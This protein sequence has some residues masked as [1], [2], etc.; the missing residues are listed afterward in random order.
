M[1]IP[2]LNEQGVLPPGVHECTL[3]EVGARFGRFA[4]TSQRPDLFA[5]LT[6]Y[7]GELSKAGVANA[8]II[9]GSF[10]TAVPHP[11]DIDLIV[12]LKEGVSQLATQ[13]PHVYNVISK[14]RVS[15][16]NR[17]DIVPVRDNT[18]DLD[19]AIAF[20]ERVR[21]SE[22]KKGLLRIEL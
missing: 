17:F 2:D 13:P 11:N 19:E 7:M 20:F 8:I 12:V 10:V 6:A 9:D 15:S 18:S 3:E 21:Y 1:P 4:E 5:R 22:I 14:R 16:R